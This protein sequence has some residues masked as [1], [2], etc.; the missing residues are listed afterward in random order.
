MHHWKFCTTG[1]VCGWRDSISTTKLCFH[2]F[3]P[4]LNGRFWLFVRKSA[5][6]IKRSCGPITDDTSVPVKAKLHFDVMTRPRAKCRHVSSVLASYGAWL[7]LLALFL[8]YRCASQ[9]LKHRP[10]RRPAAA[11]QPP[12]KRPADRGRHDECL[13]SAGSNPLILP[14]AAKYTVWLFWCLRGRV[15]QLRRVYLCSTFAMI[16]RVV[17]SGVSRC[18]RRESD[19]SQNRQKDFLDLVM[20]TLS[21]RLC[22]EPS[23]NFFFLIVA[24][25]R[26]AEN[27]FLPLL[28]ISVDS[29]A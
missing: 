5:A 17:C 19:Q 13:P 8:I 20:P 3:P 18:F 4:S 28:E 29:V 10:G 26:L 6:N 12:S 2:L 9:C 11:L 7:R 15:V 22:S 16:P 21:V 24:E 27:I 23:G 14:Q 25:K 1:S